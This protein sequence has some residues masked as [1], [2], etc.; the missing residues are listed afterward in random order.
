LLKKLLLTPI[1]GLVIALGWATPANAA[2]QNFPDTYVNAGTSFNTTAFNTFLATRTGSYQTWCVTAKGNGVVFVELSTA[3]DS[4]DLT[5]FYSSG[6]S[7]VCKTAHVTGYGPL[8]VAV[9]SAGGSGAWIRKI[10][11][12]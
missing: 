12:S 11:S 6:F 8:N 4:L 5:Y 1:I 10:E 2:V 9:Y 7:R 3:N